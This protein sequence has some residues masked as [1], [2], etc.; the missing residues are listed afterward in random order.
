MVPLFL[1]GFFGFFGFL[2]FGDGQF[3]TARHISFTVML[4]FFFIRGV[5]TAA[6]HFVMAILTD[7]NQ[8]QDATQSV[9]LRK[10]SLQS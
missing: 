5:S 10:L 6:R 9:T 7:C 4:H 2:G 8:L 1:F 3:G